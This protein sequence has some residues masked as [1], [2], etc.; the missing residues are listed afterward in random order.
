[1]KSI[2]KLSITQILNELIVNIFTV[3]QNLLIFVCKLNNH[4]H[5]SYI[6]IIYILCSL[7]DND[8]YIYFLNSRR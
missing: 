8:I 2:T 5:F 6:S 7:L 1:V 3:L 4:L